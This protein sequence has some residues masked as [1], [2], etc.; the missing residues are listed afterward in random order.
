MEYTVLYLNILNEQFQFYLQCISSNCHKV[1]WILAEQVVEFYAECYLLK[2]SIGDVDCPNCLKC[3]QLK[4]QFC[5]DRIITFFLRPLTPPHCPLICFLVVL[6]ASSLSFNTFS[7]P[8]NSSLLT[9][10]VFSSLFNTSPLPFNAISSPDH[11]T[12]SMF[13]HL[14][15]TELDYPVK[16]ILKRG[17]VLRVPMCSIY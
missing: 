2:S 10:W 5:T 15:I 3:H 1:L 14:K 9:I 7:L 16:S 13:Y 6:N 8:F 17:I 12:F 4:I 11:F